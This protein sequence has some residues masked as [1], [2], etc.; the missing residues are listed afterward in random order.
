MPAPKIFRTALL[1]AGLMFAAAPAF[2][3]A[4]RTRRGSSISSGN[5][6]APTTTTGGS[7][8]GTAARWAPAPPAWARGSTPAAPARPRH[9]RHG[10]HHRAPPDDAHRTARITRRRIT[11]ARTTAG[12][13]TMGHHGARAPGRRARSRHRGRAR[14]RW[15]QGELGPGGQHQR[16]RGERDDRS[17]SGSGSRAERPRTSPATWSDWRVP[18]SPVNGRRMDSLSA[19]PPGDAWR[20]SAAR[21]W[22]HR[23][24]WIMG[25]YGFVA[26]LPLPLSGFTLRQWMSE[27][28]V[29]LAAIGLTAN[30]GLAYTLKFL[31]SPLFDH[32]RPGPLAALGRRRGWLLVIQPLLALAAVLL[33]LSRPRAC[34]GRL[35]RG[36]GAGR[37][38]LRLPGHLRRRLAHRDL[39]RAA[40]GRGDGGLCLGLPRRAADLRRGRDRAREPAR[41]ARRAAVMAALMALGPLVTLLAREPVASRW[42][43]SRIGGRS[44]RLRHAIWSRSANSSPG[45][46]AGEILAFV[47][48]FKLGEAMAGTMAP[49][50]LPLARLRPRR[51]RAGDRLP[52]ARR[53]PRRRR[54]AAPG[55]WPATGCGRA[56]ISPAS[57][58]P[59]RC[60]SISPS[61][62]PTASPHPADQGD[63]G[64][65]RRSAWPTP[66][67][68]PISR[69]SAR[70]PTRRRNTRCCHRSPR[71]ALRTVGGLSGFLA[72]WLG[73]VHFYALTIFAALPAMLI[74]LH[75]LRRFPGGS[76]HRH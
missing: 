16:R 68:S 59:P 17:N 46:G 76:P 55:S 3:Q 26:G 37:V 22:R 13:S 49:P 41:L 20:T 64:G 63:G 67:S 12:G 9:D 60:C 23:A 40:A 28:N 38:P 70:S 31:W 43:P 30:I 35:G 2:A 45:R 53:E 71:V 15:R 19:S 34:A 72:Q 7:S 4:T 5:T 66:P 8:T 27:G 52:L 44:P 1:T 57:R 21:V 50:L 11:A 74:M 33:A 56:L 18:R 73:W 69:A 47:M 61:P 39:P 65:V 42:S 62:S 48:L 75:L 58:R 14:R 54:A 10:R 32:V 25:A 51:R 29:S 24:F 36:R 6:G